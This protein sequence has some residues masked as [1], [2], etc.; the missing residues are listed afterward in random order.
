MQN[1]CAT[2]KIVLQLLRS[3]AVC[4]SV[5]QCVAGSC[6]VLQ[7]NS[8]VTKKSIAHAVSVPND[9]QHVAKHCN[10]RKAL[11]I[12]L[13][14]TA[15]HCNSLQHTATHCNTGK[16]LGNS[17]DNTL[18]NTATPEKLWAFRCNTLQHTATHCN[19][20]QYQESSAQFE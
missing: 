16:A 12:P 3:V 19:T 15:T 10:T 11:G 7:Q 13:Q 14:H 20:L 4:C 18:Q 6:S 9:T 17:N 8:S 5:L 2:K 1:S